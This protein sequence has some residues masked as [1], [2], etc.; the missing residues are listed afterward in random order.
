MGNLASG[1]TLHTQSSCCS[2]SSLMVDDPFLHPHTWWESGAGAAGEDEVRL[3]LEDR[4][5]L[6]HV[7]MVFRSPRPAA[8]VLERSR[9]FGRTWETLKVFAENCS[10]ASGLPDGVSQQEALCTSRYSS[11]TPCAGGEASC[12]NYYLCHHCCWRLL[13]FRTCFQG[14][15][16][17]ESMPPLKIQRQKQYILSQNDKENWLDSCLK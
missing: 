1:R 3:D 12:L 13:S 8:M 5:C 17:T 11:A 4:F 14:L 15:T 9:D 7:V 10:S 6:T 16:G 2:N